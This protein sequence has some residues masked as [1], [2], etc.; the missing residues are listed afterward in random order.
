MEINKEFKPKT[1]YKS[2]VIIFSPYGIIKEGTIAIS[3]KWEQIMVYGVGNCGIDS[4]FEEV[5]KP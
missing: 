1:Y 3:E 4:M 2:K 5:P